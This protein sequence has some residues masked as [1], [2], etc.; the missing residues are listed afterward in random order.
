MSLSGLVGSPSYP[1][2]V[3]GTGQLYESSVRLR[4]LTQGLD[5]SLG[6]GDVCTLVVYVSGLVG[7]PSYRALHTWGGPAIPLQNHDGPV[8]QLREKMNEIK[9]SIK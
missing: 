5:V 2:R 7:S 3:L 4:G 8:N 9:N 1:Y 6:G